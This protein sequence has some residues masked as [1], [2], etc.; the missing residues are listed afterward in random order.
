MSRSGRLHTLARILLVLPLLGF[1]AGCHGEARSGGAGPEVGRDGGASAAD[2]AEA[3]AVRYL[4]A[5]GRGRYDSMAHLMHPEALSQIRDL[6]SLLVARDT[7]GNLVKGIFGVDGNKAFAA[8]DS[9][10]ARF[11][12]GLFRSQPGLAEVMGSLHGD[13]VGAVAEGDSLRHV[14]MRVEMG[15]TTG[16]SVSKMEV[17]SLK[18]SGGAWRVLLGGQ[19]GGVLEALR[20]QVSPRSR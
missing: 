2:S 12:S 5:L 10:Q 19:I 4:S 17:V 15:D 7:A 6:M 8:L 20:R 13:P 16:L 3:V 14:V 11:F 18:R 1:A 9:E